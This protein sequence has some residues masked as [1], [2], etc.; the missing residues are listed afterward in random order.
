MSFVYDI[1]QAAITGFLVYVLFATINIVYV[2][3]IRQGK[4]LTKYGKWA[5]VTGATDG[6]GKAYAFELAS[7]GLNV[8]L[9]SRTQSK[10]ESVAKE[11]ESKHNVDTKIVVADMSQVDDSCVSLASAIDGLDVAVLINNVGISYD[12]PNYF[13]ELSDERV[14]LLLKLNVVSLTQI[15]RVVLPG[16]VARRNGAIVNISSASGSIVTP[17]LTAYSASK[18]YVDF[19]SRGLALEYESLGIHVQSVIPFYVTSKLSKISKPTLFAPTPENFAKS[20]VRCIGYEKRTTGYWSH[21]LQR[22]ALSLLP[23]VARRNQPQGHIFGNPFNV[24]FSPYAL[25]KSVLKG[26]SMFVLCAF[27]E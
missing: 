4:D 23:E 24:R 13:H 12:Y 7:K 15:T 11:I 3:F 22:T 26:S 16:M 18:A 8:V 2:F 10:L 19:F 14:D 6:I 9:V 21:T 1:G 5:V 27:A 20:G 25:V 17:L